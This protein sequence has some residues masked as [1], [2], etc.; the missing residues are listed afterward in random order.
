MVQ[1]FQLGL[2]DSIPIVTIDGDAPQ[3]QFGFSVAISGSLVLVGSPGHSPNASTFAG[4]LDAFNFP[5]LAQSAVWS[6]AGDQPFARFG[7][8]IAVAPGTDGRPYVVAVG[9]PHRKC[10]AWLL[11]GMLSSSAS[12]PLLTVAITGVQSLC[13]WAPAKAAAALQCQCLNR[14]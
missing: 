1:T 3:Q 10:V 8:T 2:R 12:G 4:R 11:C 7:M 13:S 5:L 6:I 9:Q 14:T